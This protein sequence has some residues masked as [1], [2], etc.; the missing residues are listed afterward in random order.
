ME[1]TQDTATASKPQLAQVASNAVER[2]AERKLVTRLQ[3]SIDERGA[4]RYPLK[5]L[6]TGYAAAKGITEPQARMEINQIFEKDTGIG[7]Q[8]YLEQHRIGQG[9]PVGQLNEQSETRSR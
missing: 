3:D 8:A 1:K 4:Y 7:M 6:A 5:D 2:N 9:L